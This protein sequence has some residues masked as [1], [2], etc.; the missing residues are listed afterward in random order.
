MQLILKNGQFLVKT[1]R[2]HAHVWL[3]FCRRRRMIRRGGAPIRPRRAWLWGRRTPF[4]NL[5]MAP[6]TGLTTL[7]PKLVQSLN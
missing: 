5:L 1:L 7:S 2:I 3:D 6:P 4:A